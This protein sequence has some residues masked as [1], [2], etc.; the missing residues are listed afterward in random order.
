[1]KAKEKLYEEL[2]LTDDYLFCK[3]MVENPHL[4]KKLLEIILEVKIKKIQYLHEQEGLKQTYDG[5]GVRL[6]VYVEDTNNTVFD[7]E[8]QPVYKKDL[9]KRSRYY[10]GMIDL[11]LIS[12][13][14]SYNKLK[15]S[16]VIFIGLT[17]PFGERQKKYTFTN[18]CHEIP[19]LELNDETTKVFLNAKG[20]YGDVSEDLDNFLDYLEKKKVKGDFVSQLEAEVEKSR[21]NEEWRLEYMTLLQ[22]DRENREE[23]RA[24]GRAEGR[25][26]ER[27]QN[28]Q[29][30][31]KKGRS[32]E[33]ILD[34]DM[35]YTEAEIKQ[36][37]AELLQKV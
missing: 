1:M 17:D 12:K 18:R 32:K 4:C 25:V 5:K 10:Q 33:Y 19:E 3:I 22:R 36:A 21:N 28:I 24:E 37:E 15:K 31:L 8:M 6:D 30:M 34:L 16:Y 29:V 26:E 27:I 13:G 9:S 35:D 20:L 11:N 23:G 14:E 7:I 2:G